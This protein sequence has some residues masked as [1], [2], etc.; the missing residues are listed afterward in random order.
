M[1]K[2]LVV[3]VLALAMLSIVLTPSVGAS[4]YYVYVDKKIYNPGEHGTIYVVI[5]NNGKEPIEIKNVTIMFN[6]WLRLTEDGWDE[7]GNFSIV[8]DEPIAVLSNTTHALDPIEFTV[9]DDSR[10]VTS[11]AYIGL[12][13]SKAIYWE[14]HTVSSATV[15]L[16]QPENQ[17]L[18]RNLDNIVM[19]LTV[20]AILAIISAII[21]AAAIFLSARRSGVTWQKEE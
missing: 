3:I 12:G 7:K 21:I 10:A 19:L 15:Y 4:S 1:L 6:N 17:M 11:S 8:F 13:T 2:K 16:A 14:W 20:V 5:D 18:I 9:P